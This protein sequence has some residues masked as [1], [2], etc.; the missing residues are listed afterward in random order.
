MNQGTCA[1]LKQII[2]VVTKC[3]SRR[4]N[5]NCTCA[6]AGCQAK[7]QNESFGDKAQD[8]DNYLEKQECHLHNQVTPPAT[9][10]GTPAVLLESNGRERRVRGGYAVQ[11]RYETPE[12][13]NPRRDRPHAVRSIAPVRHRG[14]EGSKIDPELLGPRTLHGSREVPAEAVQEALQAALP[15]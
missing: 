11:I 7:F 8:S 5:T 4:R 1:A 15:P 13:Q 10:A 9:T 14:T 12:I 2:Q 6:C 3:L